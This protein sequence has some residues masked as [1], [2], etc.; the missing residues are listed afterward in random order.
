MAQTTAEP[1]AQTGAELVPSPY[2]ATD[3]T[4]P[5]AYAEVDANRL[6]LIKA[7]VAPRCDDHEV[8][9]FL[10]LCHHYG[11]DPFA[12]EAW[13]AKSER[14]QLLIMVGRDGLR[15]IVQRQGLRMD[16]DVVHAKDR[17]EV[18]RGPDGDRTVTHSYGHPAQRGDIVGAWAEVRNRQGRQ[19]GFFY[20]PLDEYKPKGASQ[21]S[22][23]SKQESVMIL[24][25]AER[26]AA[27]QATPL[28]GLLAEGEDEVING[29][30]QAL[31]EGQGDG[32]PTGL[33]MGHDVEKVIARATDL[34]HAAYSESARG[35]IEIQLGGQP[36]AM[37]A[38]WVRNAHD[39]LDQIPVDAV[40]VEPQERDLSPE[41]AET[42]E[43]KAEAESAPQAPAVATE[44][45]ESQPPLDPDRIAAMRRR[46]GQ[47]LDDADGHDARGDERAAA[48]ARDEADRYVA[49]IEAAS[50]P[51]QESLL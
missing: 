12:K 30:A 7:Q 2:A 1:A 50:D 16:G 46:V 39:E 17:F 37:V 4:A 45:S 49:Q 34:G 13:C 44:A 47:L 20:A 24:A 18:T 29:T 3:L 35:T 9:H 11:L 25:A 33:D 19:A 48:D 27:R 41:A 8:A 6:A 40:V 15:K 32:Q 36:P 26:Q 22:P 43:P 10:E 21:Y 28:S 14:G 42:P 38:Q 31:G 51:A 5:L 23:W